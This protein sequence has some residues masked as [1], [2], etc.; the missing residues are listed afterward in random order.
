MKIGERINIRHG[1]C[2]SL[3]LPLHADQINLDIYHC[4][5]AR[6]R[7]VKIKATHPCVTYPVIPK[8]DNLHTRG[9]FLTASTTISQALAALDRTNLHTQDQA[10]RTET[11]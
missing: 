9:F 3:C 5:Q 11:S 6:K 7:L 8:P 4:Y 1:K 10:K 2:T